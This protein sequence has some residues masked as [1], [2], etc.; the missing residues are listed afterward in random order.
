MWCINECYLILFHIFQVVESYRVNMRKPNK[1]IFRHTLDLLDVAPQ[2]TLFL[3]DLGPNLKGASDIGIDTI[4]VSACKLYAKYT[5]S[6]NVAR[7]T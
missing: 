1:D 4:H 6:V 3:D 5:D 2:D 7:Q